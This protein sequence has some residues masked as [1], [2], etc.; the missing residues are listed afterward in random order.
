[1]NLTP[2][3]KKLAN[4]SRLGDYSYLPKN[5]KE[6]IYFLIPGFFT[7][8]FGD[9]Y[10]E[11]NMNHLL[12]LKLDVRKIN[13]DTEGGIED[14]SEIIKKYILNEGGYK[15]IIIIGHSKGG[16]DAA[17]AIARYNLYDYIKTMIFLQS[18]WYGTYFSDIMDSGLIFK[19][20]S[21]FLSFILKKDS[22]G[23]L[24]LKH[25]ER[26]KMLNKYFFDIKKVNIICFSSKTNEKSITF[27]SFLSKILR[28]KYNVRSDGIVTEK[29]SIIPESNY[30]LIED[31]D[32][33]ETV[34]LYEERRTDSSIN[35]YPG[36]IM[37]ALITLAIKEFN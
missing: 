26:E 11:D 7:N 34:F 24:D 12:K 19:T 20:L 13:I 6:F 36:D 1:M 35:Y 28:E 22:V 21:N 2:K 16:V 32:H 17:T 15:K 37:F 18:P 8:N 30:I 25:E 4:L 27:L 3:F 9:K 31:L 10:M 14:N 5:A 29:D 33:S 23:L